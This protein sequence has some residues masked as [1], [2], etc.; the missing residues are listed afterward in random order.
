MPVFQI[1]VRNVSGTACQR[2]LGGSQREFRVMSGATRVWSSDDC[3]PASGNAATV[4]R[5]NETRTFGITWSGR[6]SAPRCA[7]ARVAAKAGSYLLI[8]RL[9]T[10]TSAATTF[11]IG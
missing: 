10:K 3:D 1:V 9:G 7:T 4:L 6:S 8:A 5:P 11:H 2:D